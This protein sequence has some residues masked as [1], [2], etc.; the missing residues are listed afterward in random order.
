M[1]LGELQKHI[2]KLIK[3]YGENTRIRADAGHNNVDIVVEV[4]ECFTCQDTGIVLKSVGGG[5]AGYG[6]KKDRCPDCKDKS[7]KN[8][9]H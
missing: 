4:P 5:W 9:R 8:D 7:W 1:T 3:D 2:A 6:D